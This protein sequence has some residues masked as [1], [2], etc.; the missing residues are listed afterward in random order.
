MCFAKVI[1][2]LRPSTIGVVD[3]EEFSYV[4]YMEVTDDV[5]GFN[6]AL[7]CIYL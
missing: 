2:L 4:Q 3:V 6:R 1:L 5:S 7:G